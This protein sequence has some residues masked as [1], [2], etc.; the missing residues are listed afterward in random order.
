MCAGF[1]YGPILIEDLSQCQHTTMRYEE[2]ITEVTREAFQKWAN[3]RHDKVV[4]R[5]NVDHEVWI[6]S[7]PFS[8][9]PYINGAG[10]LPCDEAPEVERVQRMRNNSVEF[11]KTR[12][13]DSASCFQSHHILDLQA[14]RDMNV[15][16]S[17][18]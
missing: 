14:V 6:S 8:A 4:G 2:F 17:L 13:P 3:L 9:M 7:A 10:K 1:Y 12:S 11:Y 15:G 16:E 18:Y 5:E